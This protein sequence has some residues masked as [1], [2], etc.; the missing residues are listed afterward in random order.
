MNESFLKL[1]FSQQIVNNGENACGQ[2]KCGRLMKNM[3]TTNGGL[4]ETM[5]AR[6]IYLFM[7]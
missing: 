6:T 4:N 2:N 5:H 1:N 7:L 3:I